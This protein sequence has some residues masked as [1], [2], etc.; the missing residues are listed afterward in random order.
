MPTLADF[1]AQFASALLQPVAVAN[2]DA[3]LSVYRNTVMKGLIDALAANFPSVQRLVG[4]EW[5]AGA[6]SCFAREYPPH[7]PVLAWYGA[8]FADFLDQFPPA[9]EL[10][11]LAEVARLDLCWNEAYFAADAPALTAVELQ[12]LDQP[13]LFAATLMLH[14]A[15]RLGVFKHSALSIWLANHPSMSNDASSGAV[16]I[17]AEAEAALVAR[18]HSVIETLRLNPSEYSFL[19][20]LQT[21]ASLGEAAMATLE[22]DP[23]FPLAQTLARVINVGAFTSI[24]LCSNPAE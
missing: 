7:N 9:R 18:P 21:A 11:Y 16:E 17:S 13:Q 14:P 12:A 23:Q 19:A 2:R 6:A 8:G 1:Q 4:E 15:T 5:F 20:K 24:R 10:P 22:H 3:A